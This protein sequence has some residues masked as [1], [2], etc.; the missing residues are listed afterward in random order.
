MYS[1]NIYYIIIVFFMEL[2]TCKEFIKVALSADP[3]LKSSIS[4]LT[5]ESWW[6]EKNSC[7]DAFGGMANVKM[8]AESLDVNNISIKS[9]SALQKSTEQASATNAQESK[10]KQN[11]FQYLKAELVPEKRDSTTSKSSTN[12]IKTTSWVVVSTPQQSRYSWDNIS[13]YARNWFYFILFVLVLY[14]FIK[15]FRKWVE[16]LYDVSN[17]G[18]LVYIKVLQ[19]RWD[20]ASD[21]EQK[22]EV[23]KDMKEK[24]WRM[25]QVFRAMHRIWELWVSDSIMNWVFNKAK[26]TVNLHYEKS[27]TYFIIST[28]P[29]Y[30][31]IVSSSISAQY[32]DASIEITKKPTYFGN[33]YSDII[34]MEPV[35]SSVFPIKIFKQIED[36]PLNNVIDGISQLWDTDT[37][38]VLLTI[39][40]VGSSFNKKAQKWA[41]WLYR[42][43][44]DYVNQWWQAATK[45]FKLPFKFLW[46]LFSG[47]DKKNE[48]WNSNKYQEGGKDFV[49]MTKAK[50]EALN[51][52]GEEA[53]RHAFASNLYFISSSNT[54]W[55]AKQNIRNMVAIFN[56]YKDEINN[57]LDIKEWK[58]DLLGWLLKPVWSLLAN[59]QSIPLFFRQNIFTE[60]QLTSLFHFPDGLFNKSPSIKWMD[61]KVLSSPDNIY[62]PKQDSWFVVTWVISENYL[63]WAIDKLFDKSHRAR[64]E[65]IDKIEHLIP[66]DQK[67]H[68]WYKDDQIVINDKGKWV[69]NIE[70]KHRTGLKTYKD[71]SLI[72]VNPYRNDF[73]PVYIRK[74][75]RSR[76]HYIIWKSGWGKSVLMWFLARQDAWNWDG[77][78]VIDPHWD[79]VEDIM[80]Y[81]P[82]S[83]A[84]DVVYF[85][86]WDE[87][88]PIWLNLYDIN[89]SNEMDRVVN[90]AT[91]MFLKMFGPEI[92][93]PR[94]QEYFKFGSLTL[95]EDQ[96][97]KATLLDVPRLFTDEAFRGIKV[98]KVTNP[99]VKNF[100]DRTYA[101]IWDRE[102]EE[103]IPYLTSKFV[104]FTTNSLIRNI[105]W[106][107]KSVFNFRKIMDE[108]KILLVNLSKGKIWEL[109]TQLLGMI[110][111]SQISNW[112]MSRADIPEDQRRDFFLYVDEFQ[113]FVTNT[114]ADILS[115]ARKYKLN[116]IMA[117]QYIAQLDW[118]ASNNIWE[119]SWGKKSVKDAV[120]GN[121]GTMQS[122]KIGAPDAEFLEKEYAPVLSRQDIIGISN[123]KTY[124][125]LNIENATSRVFSID[126]IRSEDYKNEKVGKVLTEYSRLKYGRDRKFVEGE[127]WA[128]LGIDLN[129]AE[130]GVESW[131]SWSNE[132]GKSDIDKNDETDP[133]QT[134][135]DK[136][137]GS[138]DQ[139]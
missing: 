61:Y 101:S 105:I 95:L 69:K 14:I 130:G 37:F 32:P 83:R 27:L 50:E 88:R 114:F 16:F 82:A 126:T 125:K 4:K 65:T 24:I 21:R 6:I 38:D 57:E 52:M 34:P 127:I 115:E 76:H 92:F 109:N 36:D 106:Q 137:I 108:G 128:R 132:T 12:T 138:I 71:A 121:V 100:R 10:W 111:V 20:S 85:N 51:I 133:V 5:Q 35:K 7:I 30:A 139:K 23:S 91:E 62:H 116:L 63:W 67:L 102:K 117:H 131:N 79:L 56:I 48:N 11:F 122:F 94:L 3:S 112:A 119:S 59:V 53:G 60:N 31:E 98:A 110:I 99:V 29:E 8:Y 46:F 45:I 39:K 41:E 97:D 89:N 49:R 58:T 84:K 19:P 93:G 104:S 54:Q 90:D 87:D 96:E 28:Y 18:R 73:T 135:K 9:N 44:S 55:N 15:V 33:K 13:W 66:Y 86:A 123:F 120:F 103:I 113:N 68:K 77:F 47:P 25:S 43:D 80:N 26:V 42:N 134:P 70:E 118:W 107:S 72:W 78:C 129:S 2:K 74:K 136:E 75:D 81:I 22:K 40:P 1:I 124:I 17:A 64:G